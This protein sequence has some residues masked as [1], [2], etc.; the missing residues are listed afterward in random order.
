[1]A[2]AEAGQLTLEHQK[3]NVADL[4]GQAVE[5]HRLRAAEKGV[6]LGI[7]IRQQLP[8]VSLDPQRIGQVLHNL[9][10]NALRYT[11]SGGKVTLACWPFEVRQEHACPSPSPPGALQPLA[12][13]HWPALSVADTGPGVPA[14]DLP[15]VFERFYRGDRSRSRSSGGT[16]L[17]LAIARQLIEAHEGKIAGENDPRGR[18]RFTFVLPVI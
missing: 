16:G 15:H 4:V 6:E 12:E 14:Q 3:V 1:L 17:G 5:R 8:A 13:G 18:A 7:E 2:L 9:L 11:P 10:A